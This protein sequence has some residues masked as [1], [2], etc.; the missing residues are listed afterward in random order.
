MYNCA[1]IVTATIIAVALSFQTLESQQEKG[2]SKASGAQSTATSDHTNESQ[3]PPHPSSAPIASEPFAERGKSSTNQDASNV[4]IQRNIEIFTGVLA[5]VGVFQLIVMFLTWL[6]YRRQAQEMRRQR[7]EMRRQRHVMFRQW[8]AMGVQA[9]QMESQLSEMQKT[10]EIE[11]KTLIL[12]YRPKIIVRNA[13]ALQFSSEIGKPGECELRFTMVNTGGS[14]A[15]I[16]AGGFIQ[17]MSVIGQSVGKIEMKEG[18]RTSI[19]QFTLQPGQQV[20]IDK[21]L[22]TGTI[23]DDEW[24]LFRDGIEVGFP[25]YIYLLGAIFYLD[26]LD[27][28]RA[29]G[30]SRKYDS[31]TLAFVPD[32]DS[33]QEYSD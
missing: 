32:K 30:I 29:T 13:K 4:N 26:D 17:L 23:N 28:P 3:E 24:A 31:K 19:S 27:I 20:T 33:E 12:Q 7:H 14:P 15:H 25:K 18:D 22:P 11:S 2:V 9:K 1:V 5:G 16:T 21:T 8:K 6:V 10:G